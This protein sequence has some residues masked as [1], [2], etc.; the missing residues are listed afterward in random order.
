MHYV[1]EKHG[2][3]FLCLDLHLQ[4]HSEITLLIVRENIE[5]HSLN[6]LFRF[7]KLLLIYVNK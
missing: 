6:R 5:Y 2:H 4:L 1:M 7:I 3:I